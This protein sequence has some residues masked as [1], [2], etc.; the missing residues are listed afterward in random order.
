MS[1]CRA[2]SLPG[3]PILQR[4][5]SVTQGSATLDVDRSGLPVDRSV[6]LPVHGGGTG[7]GRAPRGF[8]ELT[9]A[10][11]VTRPTADQ[12][13]VAALLADQVAGLPPA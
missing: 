3:G 9:S 12:R 7:G 8:F 1:S 2:H 13:R 10:S 11:H 5:G 6:L 4:D